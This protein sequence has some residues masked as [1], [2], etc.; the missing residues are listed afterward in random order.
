[1]S[2]DLQQAGSQVNVAEIVHHGDKLLIP[3]GMSI[4][5]AMDLL[6][7][8]EQYLQ[9]AVAIQQDYNVFPW[10]GAHALAKVLAKRY[11][12]T[13][14]KPTPGML[15]DK[16]PE[17]IRIEVAPGKFT[18]VPLGRFS[19][20]G[21]EGWLQTAVSSVDGRV[22]FTLKAG[23]LRGSEATV[24][25]I[26]ADLTEYLKTGSIYQGQ[27]IKLR[28]SGDDG[29][30]IEVPTPQFLDTSKIDADMLVFSNEV[31][32]A[33]NTNL[34][35]P[36]TRAG[37]LIQH[38]IPVKRG[39]LLGGTYG[40]GKTL[41]ATVA[42]KLAVEAG[43]T[44]IY[45]PRADELSQAVKFAQQY[46]SPA[47]VVF[48]EDVDRVMDGE[49]SIE[50]DDILN[51][52]DGIDSKNSNIIV[53]LTTNHLDQINQAMLRPGRLD[54]VIEVSPPDA[55]A[56]TKLIRKYGGAVIDP[57]AKLDR[58]GEV[59]QGNIPAVIA[60]VVKR[61][62]L[63]QLS[64]QE[65]GTA[66]NVIS[67]DALLDAAHTMKR[68]LELLNRERVKE[69]PTIEDLVGNVVAKAVNG[70]GEAYRLKFQRFAEA[71]QSIK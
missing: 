36:I 10:D 53:V 19:I 1:M 16:P 12:W 56:V 15:G 17:L 34:F 14:M 60:E 21:V 43:I 66:L 8:R 71:V 13:D 27:A 49:R 5:Q 47:S 67:E 3:E 58:V 52:I 59:M 64:L 31:Q 50:M 4:P 9:T 24:R 32:T 28:F 11:G 2:K 20:P 35:T 7:R 54:A 68:Q 29:D 48:C 45:V 30:P 25:Q 26:F 37:E 63:S 57:A 39:V 38:G 42:S 51:I 41:A 55:A 69:L 46:Q 6:K 44:F 33:V 23:I 18:E 70:S 65:P 22:A 61:A 62:K 40:T